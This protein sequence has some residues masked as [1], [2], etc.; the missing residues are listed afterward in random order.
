MINGA[1]SA[2]FDARTFVT[3]PIREIARRLDISRKAVRRYLR[4]ETTESSHAERRS[5]SGLD[6]CSVQLSPWLKSETNT[7]RRQRRNLNQ[8]HE[9]LKELGYEGSSDRVAVFAKQPR[10]VKRSGSILRANE[11]IGGSGVIR[12][13]AKSLGFL[14]GQATDT[15]NRTYK[16]I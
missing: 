2:S 11:Q 5:T 9:Y 13:T 6:K 8:I 3:R 1:Y 12:T 15:Y 7:P 16:K 4:S 10:M 14:F